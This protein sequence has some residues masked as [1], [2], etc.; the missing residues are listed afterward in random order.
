MWAVIIGNTLFGPVVLPGFF[1]VIAVA[2]CNFLK[3]VLDPWQDPIPQSLPKTLVLIHDSS[4]NPSI[5][6]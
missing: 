2:Y 5:D 6:T 4:K 3:E 1:K